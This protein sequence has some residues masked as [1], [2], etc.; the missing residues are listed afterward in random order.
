MSDT[1]VYDPNKAMFKNYA[2]LIFDARLITAVNAMF[3]AGTTFKYLFGILDLTISG[4]VTDF[5]G[6]F[7]IE[8]IQVSPS[9]KLVEA[10]SHVNDGVVVTTYGDNS[11][12]FTPA[13]FWNNV[14]KMIEHEKRFS[15]QKGSILG[16]DMYGVVFIVEKVVKEV[17]VRFAVN[18]YRESWGGK[19]EYYIRRFPPNDMWECGHYFAIKV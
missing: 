5:C 9:V 15:R 14:T 2:P 10:L 18:L 17:K 13:Q 7:R 12:V 6:F 11:A 3:N 8:D 4:L 1:V 16:D 19:T